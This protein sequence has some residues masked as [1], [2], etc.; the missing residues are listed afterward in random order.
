[1]TGEIAVEKELSGYQGLLGGSDRAGGMYS[2][3]GGSNLSDLPCAVIRLV[4]LGGALEAVKL[5]RFTSGGVFSLS[6][7]K[8]V[9]E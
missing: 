2:P 6:P 9:V 8:I 5:P 7:K 4:F 1:M 3:C